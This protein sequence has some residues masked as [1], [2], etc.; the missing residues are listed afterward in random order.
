[1]VSELRKCTCH[2][3]SSLALNL[4]YL[5]QYY[6]PLTKDYL[7]VLPQMCRVIVFTGDSSHNSSSLK[8]IIFKFWSNNAG[9][10]TVI[11][12]GARVLAIFSLNFG[13]ANIIISNFLL[14]S[15]RTFLDSQTHSNRP[16]G[17]S[18][19]AQR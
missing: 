15:W 13:A 18:K 17:P 5:K 2:K 16:T 1:M 9:S 10:F 14:L 7:A 3:Y 19:S 12:K 4:H 8:H 6:V 11:A